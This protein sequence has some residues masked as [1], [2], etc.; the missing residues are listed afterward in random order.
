M[1]VKV[2]IAGAVGYS[3]AELLRIFETHS[4]VEL[5]AVTSESRTGRI[6]DYFPSYSRSGHLTLEKFDA[7]AIAKSADVVFLATPADVSHIQLPHLLDANK[8]IKVI[9]ISGA[10]RLTD[11]DEFK[12][13]YGFSHKRLDL[14]GEAVYGLSEVYADKIKSAR[15]ITNPGCYPSSVLIPLIPLAREGAINGAP[16][17]IDSRSGITGKGKKLVEDSLFCEINENSYAY[18][19]GKHQHTPEIVRFLKENGSDKEVLFTPSLIPVNRGIISSVYYTSNIDI[20]KQRDILTSFYKNAP[21]IKLLP[22]G[23]YPRIS[24]VAHTN[25]LHF[26]VF[27]D[28]RSGYYIINSVIDNLLKGA[29]GQ[30]VQNMN[31]MC[32]FDEKEGLL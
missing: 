28:T 32:G 10:F 25:Q 19:I 27:T 4:E 9:D 24:D 13:Y 3:G 2:G 18:K 15:I 23:K 5:T 21:F 17:I 1:S 26:N 30:A 7:K 22:E 8:K 6:S 29:A 12:H 16:V 20:T 31:I 11:G 14:A